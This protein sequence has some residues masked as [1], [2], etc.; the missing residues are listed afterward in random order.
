MGLPGKAGHHSMKVT[1]LVLG[2]VLWLVAVP[3]PPGGSFAGLLGGLIGSLIAATGLVLL[4]RLVWFGIA[5]L[6]G[7]LSRRRVNT[8]PF[9]G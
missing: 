6:I 3:H 4:C 7:A 2:V 8:R 1:V 9:Q 5:K